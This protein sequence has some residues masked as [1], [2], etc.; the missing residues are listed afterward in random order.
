MHSYAAKCRAEGYKT[1]PGFGTLFHSARSVGARGRSIR[2]TIPLS[3]KRIN[4]TLCHTTVRFRMPIAAGG[5]CMRISGL[6]NDGAGSETGQ[7]GPLYP[8][9]WKRGQSDPTGVAGA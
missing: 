2:R 4:I 8:S 1:H 5:P 3:R 6:H 9:G 7:A